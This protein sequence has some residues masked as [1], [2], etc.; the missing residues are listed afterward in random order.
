MGKISW[1]L[2]MSAFIS[3][4]GGPLHSSLP[5]VSLF[6]WRQRLYNLSCRWHTNWRNILNH[7]HTHAIMKIMINESCFSFPFPL[8]CIAKKYL[9][10]DVLS[11]KDWR[12]KLTSSNTFTV[13]CDGFTWI[14][15]T[16]ID[17]S[18]WMCKGDTPI[19][20]GVNEPRHPETVYVTGVST[21]SANLG[22]S[23][24]FFCL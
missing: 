1:P 18:I 2:L 17:I 3:P 9:G 15:I 8:S 16:G 19:D 5:C 4:H 12:P 6:S 13:V 11:N 20:L 22:Y 10:A 14:D 24:I 23:E 7:T 21:S